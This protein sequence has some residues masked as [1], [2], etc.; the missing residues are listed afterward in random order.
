[1]SSVVDSM[2]GKSSI[3]SDFMPSEMDYITDED[4]EAGHMHVTDEDDYDM[5]E[6]SYS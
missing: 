1:M 3:C 5:D 4:E 2:A 6:D